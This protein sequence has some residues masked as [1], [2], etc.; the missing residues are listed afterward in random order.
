MKT[1]HI[2]SLQNQESFANYSKKKHQLIQ[3]DLEKGQYNNDKDEDED[4]DED[5]DKYKRDDEDKDD[6]RDD[7]RDDDKDAIESA[8]Q[9]V[10][11]IM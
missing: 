9:E 3:G 11:R 2:L 10:E 7:E 6:E 5:E 1:Y 8:I 4:E